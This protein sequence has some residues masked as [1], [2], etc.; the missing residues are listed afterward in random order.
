MMRT[1]LIPRLIELVGAIPGFLTTEDYVQVIGISGQP[2]RIG[3]ALTYDLTQVYTLAVTNKRA[4]I[5]WLEEKPEAITRI[6]V[7]N[8]QVSYEKHKCFGHFNSGSMA[9]TTCHITWLCETGTKCV[10]R[11]VS[12]Q[13]F[14]KILLKSG[15]CI[16]NVVLNATCV[17][18]KETSRSQA[19]GAL[20]RAKK[21]L[22][23]EGFNAH[24]VEH[25]CLWWTT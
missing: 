13:N 3:V 18:F 22:R 14:V 21:V 10:P 6:P 1:I 4:F 9:C 25:G 2:P 16:R 11:Q 17:R 20:R 5:T 24:K 19:E 23:Q 7:T 8:C 12:K 15:M